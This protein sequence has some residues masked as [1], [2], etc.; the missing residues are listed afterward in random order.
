MDAPM[1]IGEK[2]YCCNEQYYFSQKATKYGDDQ[3]FRDIMKSE[4]PA[5]MMRIGRRAVNHNKIDWKEFEVPVMTKANV[6]KFKQNEHV[7]AVLRATGTTTLGE[8]SNNSSSGKFWGTGL[9][10]SHKDRADTNKWQGNKMGEILSTI[11]GDL[12]EHEAMADA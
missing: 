9:P 3:A 7:R 10:M 6:E 2:Q 11:R 12:P 5:E 4:D 1:T 8:A